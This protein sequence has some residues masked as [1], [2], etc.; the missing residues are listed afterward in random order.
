M[1]ISF[2]IVTK[3]RPDELQ[4]S[5]KQLQSIFDSERHEVL[6]YIDG[7]EATESI[8][9]QFPWV[10]WYVGKDSISASPARNFLY[11]KAVGEIFI[12]LDDDAHLIS[13]KPVETIQSYFKSNENLGILA[14]LEIKGLFDNPKNQLTVIEKEEFLTIEFI[15]SG[16]AIRKKVYDET[17][18]FP[19]WMDIYG[20][21]SCVS[22]EVMNLGYDIL[23]S[24]QVAVNHR[25]DVEKRKLQGKNYFRFQRQ[26]QNSFRLYVIYSRRP[27]WKIA[28]LLFHNF[29]KY[30]LSDRRYFSLYAYALGNMIAVLPSILQRRKKMSKVAEQKLRTLKGITY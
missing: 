15:G 30:A 19:I 25:I 6:V 11:A 18:G 3:N 16:F 12:G 10:K 27:F 28:K 13:E 7:C 17:N 5:L 1:E 24:N 29:K 4:W 2:L 20:E 23:F 9:V 8:Q 14:F 22:L 21:E 26:L